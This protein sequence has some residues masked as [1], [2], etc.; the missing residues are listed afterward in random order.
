M[1]IKI[2]FDKFP[3]DLKEFI[4]DSQLD[5]EEL[6]NTVIRLLKNHAIKKM[7]LNDKSDF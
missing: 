1:Q 6:Q 7:W 5:N 2:N 3:K 4:L